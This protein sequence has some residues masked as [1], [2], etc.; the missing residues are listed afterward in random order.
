MSSMALV[1][2]LSA[3]GCAPLAGPVGRGASNAEVAARAAG[4]MTG[5]AARGGAAGAEGGGLRFGHV[6]HD[7]GVRVLLDASPD[8]VWAAKGAPTLV[9]KGSPVVT[10]REVD[11]SRLPSN[12]TSVIGSRVDLMRAGELVCEATVTG[13]S[14]IGRVEPYFGAR[15]E[16]EG[17]GGASEKAWSAAEIAEEAWKLSDPGGRA[18]AAEL[19]D[20]KGEGCGEA[21]WARDARAPA[22]RVAKARSAESES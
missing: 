6:I 14:L 17:G 11:E 4:G 16:W 19:G 2:M 5:G 10:R 12:F 22:P 7:G 13:L 21:T 18:L 3:L 20:L 8:E 1:T 9:S 15:G